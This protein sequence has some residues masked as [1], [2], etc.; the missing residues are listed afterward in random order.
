M[1]HRLLTTTGEG[2]ARGPGDRRVPNEGEGLGRQPG[3]AAGPLGNGLATLTGRV[4]ALALT[5]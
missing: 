1:V 3:A 4:P 2:V 5:G